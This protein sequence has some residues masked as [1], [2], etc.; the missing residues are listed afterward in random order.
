MTTELSCASTGKECS[1]TFC[2]SSPRL[3]RC[4]CKTLGQQSEAGLQTP[5]YTGEEEEYNEPEQLIG[6]GL[7]VDSDLLCWRAHS[8]DPN[9][10]STVIWRHQWL[11]PEAWARFDC[12]MV[13]LLCRYA[14]RDL[15]EHWTFDLPYEGC[16]FVHD[17]DRKRLRSLKIDPWAAEPVA[18][19]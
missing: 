4:I 16:R 11:A 1:I 8:P 6:W 2:V 18:D 17:R 3:K 19:I 14:E 10:W 9:Q 7:T 13:E 15:P 12:G 5:N